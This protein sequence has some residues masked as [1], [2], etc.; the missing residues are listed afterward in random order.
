MRLLVRWTVG[1][2]ALWLTV[3][4]AKEFGVRGLALDSAIGTFVA[5]AALGF[6]NHVVRP[7]LVLIAFPLNCLTLGLF[8]LVINAALFQAVGMLHLGLV[9]D[10]FV[11]ALF[12]SITLSIVSAI[13]DFALPE[14][15]RK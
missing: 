9:V 13:L 11:P 4:A 7:I 14:P 5:I 3:A 15:E 8:R 12:G 6:A 2:L 10:G 1:A